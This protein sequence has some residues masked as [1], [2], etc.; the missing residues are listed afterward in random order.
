M[1][2][3]KAAGI[4]GEKN[5]DPMQMLFLISGAWASI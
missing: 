2:E 3:I 5:K 1:A 4:F